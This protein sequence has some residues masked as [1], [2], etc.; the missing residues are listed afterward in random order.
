MGIGR[1]TPNTAVVGDS[2]WIPPIVKQWKTVISY[3]N[4]LRYMDENRLNK[5][6]NNWAENSFRRS[7][8]CKNSLYRLYRQFELSGISNL[9]NDINIDKLYVTNVI[10]EKLFQTQGK[11]D[12]EI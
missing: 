3:W 1:Y 7:R 10:Q 8:T 12:M 9:F 2:G 4:R 5:K 11:S 6:I